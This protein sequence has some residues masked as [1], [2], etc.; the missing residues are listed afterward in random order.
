MI[1]L[2]GFCFTLFAL[3]VMM[4][5]TPDL[6]SPAPWWTYSIYGLALWLY[7]TFDNVD[8]K[9]ARKTGTS[10]PLGELFDHGI[11]ALNCTVQSNVL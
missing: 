3:V 4:L 2:L 6:A 5:T 1:T 10:S 11:D 8:G 7:S 9:Q